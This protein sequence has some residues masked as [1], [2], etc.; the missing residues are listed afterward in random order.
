MFKGQKISTK[1]IATIGITMVIGFAVLLGNQWNGLNTGIHSLADQNRLAMT[2]LLAQNVSGGIR[3][4]KAKVIETSY[5]E[6]VSSSDSDVATVVTLGIDGAELTRFEHAELPPVEFTSL[7]SAMLQEVSA[8]DTL[9]RNAGDHSLVVATAHNAKNGKPV[10]YVVVGFTN[11]ELNAFVFTESLVA[12]AISLIAVL[13]TMIALW[14]AVRL[15]FSKPMAEMQ[16]VASELAN[17]DGDLTRRLDLGTRDELGELAGTINSF[18]DKLQSVMGNVVGSVDEVTQTLEV[19]RSAAGT[20]QQLLNEH[21]GELGK[22]NSALHA[23]S[24]SLEGMSQAAQELSGATSE[25]NNAAHSANSMADDAVSAVS[26]LTSKVHEV[27]E[28]IR[29]LETRSQNIGSVLDV[30]KSIA[31]QTNLLALNAA[32]E[33]ARAGEQGRGFAVVADEVR[34]LASRTQQSTEEIQVIIESLQS[35]AQKAVTTMEQSQ[36]DVATSASHIEQVKSTL[37]EIAKHIDGIANTNASVASDINEQSQVARGITT[38]I[39]KISDLSVSVLNN[40]T[41]TSEACEELDRVNGQLTAQV[42]FFKV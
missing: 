14:L 34:T 33:A 17:G 28:V 22:A 18:V 21:S 5:A 26:G 20:N 30:I 11:A 13:G 27:E 24:S 4:K 10:G 29:E 40:G 23:M 42:G 37:S 41:K 16:T 8:S 35:G 9:V 38:N 19:A 39:D 7:T 25:A 12:A 2:R 32:I 1:L 3:W 6:F 15:F 36:G 31:E